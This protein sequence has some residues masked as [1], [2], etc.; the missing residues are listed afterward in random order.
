MRVSPGSPSPLGATWDGR[1]VNFA[2]FSRNA[3][4]VELCLFDAAG[5]E[6]DR[7]RL[8]ERSG[9][10][11]HGYM[12]ELRPGQLYGYRVSGPYDPERGHRF[13]PHKLLLDPYARAISGPIKPV[14]ASFG[15][16]IGDPARDLSRSEEDS[17][18]VMPRCVVT[19]NAF[20]WDGDHHPETPWTQTVIYECHVK[21]MTALHPGVPEHLRGTYLGMASDAVLDHLVSLGVTAVELLP[22]HHTLIERHLTER[23]LTNYWGYSSIG[24][25]APDA[26]YASSGSNGEQ[27]E[28]FKAMVKALHRA[29]I[30]VILDVVFNHSGE[31][32]ELGPTVCFRGIDNASYYRLQ[33]QSPRYYTDTTGCGNSLNVTDPRVLQLIL[34]SLRYWVTEMHVDGFRFDLAVTLGRDPN[35]F[36]RT[37]RFFTALQQDPV[38]SEIKL[39]AEP[40]DLGPDGY[41]VG[42]FS[43]AW[44]EWNDKYRTT[45]RRFWLD[46][47]K[48]L[49]ELAS[50][51][52]GS[53]DIFQHSGR[54]PQATVN[55]VTCHDGFTLNDLVSYERKHNDANGWDNTDGDDANW[56]RNW[57]AEGDTDLVAVRRRRQQA[58]RNMI[59]TLAFS[60]G[61]PMLAHGDELQRTQGG[62]NNAYCQDNPTAWIDW[63]LSPEAAAHLEFTRRVLALRRDNPVF[64]RR[65]FFAGEALGKRAAKDVMWLHPEGRELHDGDWHDAHAKVLGMWIPGVAVDETDERGRPTSGRSL[66]LI[67]NGGAHTSLFRLPPDLAAGVWSQ[68]LFTGP[69]RVIAFR[70]G[71]AKVAARSL[72]L[73]QREDGA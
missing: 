2:L 64:R 61:V 34:D 15:Y 8:P 67:V 33:P 71:V 46:E 13:N 39:I 16:R 44:A 65:R 36:D 9:A 53:A 24:F 31:G 51:L 40:W 59:A 50:R 45:V 1:G 38:L 66:L 27:V 11:W 7:A 3:T 68:A 20:P 54:R 62:N 52:S 35:H 23:Q 70:D 18:P 47:G 10:V 57:G 26:R 22:V 5:V 63:N 58:M 60:Q 37:G 30:E 17:A 29:N 12:P 28:D 6:T 19:S 49:P 56:S 48:N 14:D 55:L 69:G 42:G 73:L 43:E 25:F 32:N 41:Q 72:A 4:A 21:G